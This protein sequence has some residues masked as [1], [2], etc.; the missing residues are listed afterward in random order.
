MRFGI[1]C[2]MAHPENKKCPKIRQGKGESR[3]QA[4]SIGDFKQFFS[5]SAWEL[6]INFE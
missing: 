6:E 2:I 5:F 1:I 4:S 3:A